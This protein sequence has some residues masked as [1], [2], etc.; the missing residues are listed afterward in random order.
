[1]GAGSQKAIVNELIDAAV[2]T[3]AQGQGILSGDKVVSGQGS[4]VTDVA[5]TAGGT[6]TATEQGIIND[7]VTAVNALLAELRTLGIIAT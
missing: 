3:A 6:Y 1:M 4:A 2:I 7:T 5:G